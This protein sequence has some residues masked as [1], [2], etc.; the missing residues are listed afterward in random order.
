MI[1]EIVGMVVIVAVSWMVG[2]AW[3]FHHQLKVR[4]RGGGRVSR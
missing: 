2:H 4:R 1:V 3:E